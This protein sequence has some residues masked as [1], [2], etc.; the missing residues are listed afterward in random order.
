MS[1]QEKKLKDKEKEET[2]KEAHDKEIKKLDVEID[3][4]TLSKDTIENEI[5]FKQNLDKLAY[6]IQKKFS[7]QKDYEML[8]VTS[9]YENLKAGYHFMTTNVV[10]PKVREY[11]CFINVEDK[12][13]FI[14]KINKVSLT[15]LKTK[16]YVFPLSLVLTIA[17]KKNFRIVGQ[18]YTK[19]HLCLGDISSFRLSE[20]IQSAMSSEFMNKM[21]E[22]KDKKKM[23][24]SPIILILVSA[25]SFALTFYFM[26]ISVFKKAILNFMGDLNIIP[27]E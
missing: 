7:L 21:F 27:P 25:V 5:D 12:G 15:S 2:S 23:L 16:S 20:Q 6:L 24:D 9:N 14:Q 22:H 19:F 3:N 4:I 17:I 11:A 18:K 8:Q 26:F 13:Y 10:L 1:K